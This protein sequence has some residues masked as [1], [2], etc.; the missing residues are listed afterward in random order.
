MKRNIVKYE[1]ERQ[2]LGINSDKITDNGDNKDD[3]NMTKGM[4]NMKIQKQKIYCA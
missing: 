3:K 1:E 4:S 2:R